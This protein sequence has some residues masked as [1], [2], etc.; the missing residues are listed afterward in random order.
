MLARILAAPLGSHLGQPVVVEAR[1][2]AGGMVAA[3]ALTRAAADGYTMG[4][5]TGGHA[6]SAAFGRNL[7]F[8]PVD[9]FTWIAQVVEYGFV[10]TV[11]ADHPAADLRALLARAAA[12]NGLSYG[13]AGTGST[14]HLAG[15]LLAA[16]T[17]TPLVHV[18]YRGEADAMTALMAGNIECAIV[19]SATALPQIRSG[20]VR[21]VALTSSRPS[22]S[23]PGVPTI[24]ATVP[25]YVVTT[26]AG[27]AG[28]PGLP[29]PVL[30][31]LNGAV[32][33][34]ADQP[35]VGGRMAELVDG[36]VRTST[37]AE[38]RGLVASEMGRWRRLIDERQVRPD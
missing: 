34:L 15:E 14:H 6:V 24:E 1:P 22:A 5:M 29:G 21:A 8:D 19:T 31:A 32:L 13:S 4:L 16:M 27:L 3:A 2:G 17:G 36:T 35:A 38:L 9:G 26:W 37:S 30:D 11:R 18:P 12:P 23:L 7:T 33:R 10:V 28:P 20:R 25:G